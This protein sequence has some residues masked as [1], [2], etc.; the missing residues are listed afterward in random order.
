V[1]YTIRYIM[2]SGPGDCVPFTIM[3]IYRSFPISSV[4]LTRCSDPPEFV[5]HF[6][7]HCYALSIPPSRVFELQ[8]RNRL[9]IFKRII[10]KYIFDR[11]NQIITSIKKK[12]S[13][14][15]VVLYSVALGLI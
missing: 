2:S 12:K 9:I 11:K 5:I 10:N 15:N 4:E 13:F 8:I 14:K 7:F 6:I 3:Q 1:T